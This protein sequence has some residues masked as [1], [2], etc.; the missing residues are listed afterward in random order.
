MY[1]SIYE[2]YLKYK[3]IL[4]SGDIDVKNLIDSQALTKNNLILTALGNQS[5]KDTAQYTAILTKVRESEA[6]GLDDTITAG[7]INAEML[8]S[9]NYQLNANT[10]L[11]TL[12][13][14][15]LTLLNSHF[16]DTAE[17]TKT[18]S[19][20]LGK[21]VDIALSAAQAI[22]D[23]QGGSLSTLS[24]EQKY[25]AAKTAFETNTDQSKS[26]ELGKAF[27]T[28]SQGKY[29][30]GAGY[31]TDYNSVMSQLKDI[32]GMSGDT[33]ADKQLTVLTQIKDI[34][35]NNQSA[36][37]NGLV[38]N[39]PLPT[40]VTATASQLTDHFTK[41]ANGGITNGPSIAGEGLYREAVIPLPDGRNV[42]VRVDGSA[43][44]KETVAELKE[45]NQLL[46]E[47]LVEARAGVRTAAAGHSGTIQAIESTAVDRASF[48]RV[49]LQMAV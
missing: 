42:P 43:D 49:A 5:L 31:Q 38:N 28:E 7:G 40:T 15:A 3:D 21:T 17:A 19:T 4:K 29:A 14:K 30:S 37:Q 34:L 12:S 33:T 26:G 2:S 9:M 22:K 13:V 16:Q 47:L 45:Q 46:R 41:F 20:A 27:L 44:N 39:T 32:A 18:L 11:S 8:K 6:Y 35:A 23:I 36:I 10:D 25:L 48:N 24:P 1:D